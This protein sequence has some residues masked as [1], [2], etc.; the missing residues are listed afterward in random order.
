MKSKLFFLLICGIS[1]TAC[2]PNQDSV[3]SDFAGLVKQYITPNVNIHIQQIRSGNGGRSGRFEYVDF[4]LQA[5]KNTHF[6]SGLALNA[7]EHIKDCTAALIYRKQDDWKISQYEV[8]C[9]SKQGF[10]FSA[11]LN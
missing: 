3:R 5:T 8:N 7:G 1:V 11:T 4:S 2:G 9:K 10:V 6:T